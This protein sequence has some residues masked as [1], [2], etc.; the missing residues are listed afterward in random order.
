ME[1]LEAASDVREKL[2][3]AVLASEIDRAYLEW[4]LVAIEGLEI[5]GAAATPES[6]I[7]AGPVELAAEILA[8]IKAQCVL[9]EDERKN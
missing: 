7:E 3:A 5:D 1:Y 4:G 8:R 9:T 6:L 2:E